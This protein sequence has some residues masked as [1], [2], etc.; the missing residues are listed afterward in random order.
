VVLSA[1]QPQVR[2]PGI[3]Q[4]L[5]RGVAEELVE[6]PGEDGAGEYA[7]G[8]LGG[9][10]SSLRSRDHPS[11]GGRSVPCLRSRAAPEAAASPL[12]DDSRPVPLDR[13]RDRAVPSI[14]A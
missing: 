9:A 7:Q 13:D 11:G 3:D 10:S 5:H 4:E 6:W 8:S 1:E 12:R 14:V 2:T